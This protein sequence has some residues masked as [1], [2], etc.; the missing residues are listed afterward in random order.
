MFS[1]QTPTATVAGNTQQPT[2]PAQPSLFSGFGQQQSQPT[3]SLVGNLGQTQQQQQPGPSL[4]GQSNPSGS[5]PG[6]F[7]SSTATAG[8]GQPS[9]TGGNPAF[10][11]NSWN[12]GNPLLPKSAFGSGTSAGPNQPQQQGTAMFGQQPQQQQS[13]G[14]GGS[15]FGSNLNQTQQPCA[16]F[17]YF[18]LTL[19]SSDNWTLFQICI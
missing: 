18:L 1:T 14:F 17:F 9:A 5:A 6:L 3:Q 15:L 2:G 19:L 16:A 12:S 4:L 13:T 10:G 7:L 11:G 8:A